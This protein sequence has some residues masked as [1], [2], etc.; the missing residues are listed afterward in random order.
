MKLGAVR[1]AVLRRA[2]ERHGAWHDQGLW[3]I[4]RDEW[5]DQWRARPRTAIH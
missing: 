5:R 4:A 1:E 2:F 3:A